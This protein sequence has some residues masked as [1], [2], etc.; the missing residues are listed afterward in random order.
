MKRPLKKPEQMQKKNTQN[1]E[2]S[3]KKEKT[4]KDS[5][6]YKDSKEPKIV[7]YVIEDKTYVFECPHCNFLVQVKESDLRC[8]IFRH[9]VYKANNKPIPPHASKDQCDKLLEQDLIHGCAKPFRLI[10][11]KIAGFPQYTAEICDY[12]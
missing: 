1:N 4:S 7:S 12:I 5:E 3:G 2:I 11:K 8:K 6:E 9:A 10:T